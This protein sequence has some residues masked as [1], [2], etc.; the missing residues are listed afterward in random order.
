MPPGGKMNDYGVLGH[1]FLYDFNMTQPK[2]L[3]LNVLIIKKRKNPGVSWSG[4]TSYQGHFQ[5]GT[6]SENIN[7][8]VKYLC[9]NFYPF[10]VKMQF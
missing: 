10:F 7:K 5:C 4:A 8:V 2:D 3:Q 9:A 1:A 6:I